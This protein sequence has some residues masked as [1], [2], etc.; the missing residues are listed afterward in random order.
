MKLPLMFFSVEKI[1]NFN[2]PESKFSHGGRVPQDEMGSSI[3][4]ESEN[5]YA[6]Y[7]T[8]V[9]GTRRSKRLIPGLV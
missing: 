6:L 1:E 7:F 3:F 5:K 8:G 4:D 2:F 9:V